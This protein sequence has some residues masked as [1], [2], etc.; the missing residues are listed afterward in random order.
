MFTNAKSLYVIGKNTQVRTLKAGVAITAGT[1]VCL[2]ASQDGEDRIRY[3]TPSTTSIATEFVGIAL[4]SQTTVGGDVRVAVAGY[5][6]DVETDGN[7][8]AHDSLIAETARV[9]TYANTDTDP[10]IGVALETDNGNHCD[11]CL[12]GYGLALLGE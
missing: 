5:I 12:N 6:E 2:D 7:V 8:A 9:K 4:E 10:I 1:A 11:I 3:V